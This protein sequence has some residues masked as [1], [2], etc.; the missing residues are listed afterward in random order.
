THEEWDASYR[1]TF[2]NLTKEVFKDPT[3]SVLHYMMMSHGGELLAR[4]RRLNQSHHEYV[5]STDSRLKD[6]EEK[7]ASLTGLEVQVCTLKKQVSELNEKLF[8]SDASFS[9]SKAKGKERKNVE[10]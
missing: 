6:Y 1:P 2:R 7:V 5:L 3:M 10:Y 4:Y 8:S 9:K